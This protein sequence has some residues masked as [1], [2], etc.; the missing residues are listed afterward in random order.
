MKFRGGRMKID[1]VNKLL[2][3][4]LRSASIVDEY[5]FINQYCSDMGL[6]IRSYSR[7]VRDGVKAVIDLQAE[8][9]RLKDKVERLEDSIEDMKSFLKDVIDVEYIHFLEPEDKAK[10]K[11]YTN[12][13][14]EVEE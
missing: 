9:I 7:Y 3:I 10:I 2:D 6:G 5:E 4:C 12:K 14:L 11:A 8:N 13:L 1:K